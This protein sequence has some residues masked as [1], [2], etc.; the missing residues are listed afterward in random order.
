MRQL[1]MGLNVLA[2]AIADGKK[3]VVFVHSEGGRSSDLGDS[4]TSFAIVLGPKGPG[5]L[6]DRCY[7]NMAA[8]NASSN[9]MLKN[10]GGTASALAWDVSDALKA[11]DGTAAD[12]L[13]PSTGDVGMGVIQFLE[14]KTAKEARK[15]LAPA[16][17]RYVKL[18]RA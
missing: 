13:V 1:A 9:N 16:D 14:E 15:D 11:Q 2:K 8:I 18:K 4:R 12:N 10:P 6:D 17:G 5:N 7:G 3:L